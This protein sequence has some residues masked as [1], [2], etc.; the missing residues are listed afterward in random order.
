MGPVPIVYVVVIL[1]VKVL[2]VKEALAATFL[3]VEF[4]VKVA[5]L[6]DKVAFL[7]VK[8]AFLQVKVVQEA[9]QAVQEESL[10]EVSLQEAW[11]RSKQ[12]QPHKEALA[13]TFLQVEFQVKVAFLPVKVVQ[14]ASQAVQEASLQ[15]VSLQEAW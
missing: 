8:V 9:S 2:Q 12:Q 15:E 14:E 13:A 11:L 4:Q 3:Q 1:Q 5:F 7:P 10:Q 6:Q